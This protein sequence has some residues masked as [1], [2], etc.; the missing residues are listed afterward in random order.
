TSRHHIKGFKRI[1]INLLTRDQARELIL[2]ES[3]K[4]H[5]DLDQTEKGAL[6]SILE[7]LDGL[8]L[9]LEVAGAYIKYMDYSFQYYSE[10]LKSSPQIALDDSFADS[11]TSHNQY[12]LIKMSPQT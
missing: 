2:L 5:E 9:A 10:I 7:N 4:K 6:E 12:V 1:D 3:N 11:F 8:P